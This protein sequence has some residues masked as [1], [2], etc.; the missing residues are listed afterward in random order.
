MSFQGMLNIVKGV[1]EFHDIEA[2]YWSESILEAYLKKQKVSGLISC[3][4]VLIKLV[5]NVE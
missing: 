2:Q 4:S 1:S 5:V 3:M